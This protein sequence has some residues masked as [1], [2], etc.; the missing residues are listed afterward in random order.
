MLPPR[1]T[2]DVVAFDASRSEATRRGGATIDV[3]PAVGAL[4]D[5]TNQPSRSTNRWVGAYAASAIAPSAPTG[6]TSV[7][8]ATAPAGANSD[9]FA[10]RVEPDAQAVT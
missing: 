3:S 10:G 9:Q 8:V 2:T 1:T 4:P 7:V 6:T 5:A